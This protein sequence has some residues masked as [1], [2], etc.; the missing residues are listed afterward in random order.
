MAT[1]EETDSGIDRFDP[2]VPDPGEEWNQWKQRWEFYVDSLPEMTDKRKRAKLLHT[3]GSKVQEIYQTLNDETKSYETA[4]TVLDGYFAP[5]KNK[6]YQRYLFRQITPKPGQKVDA[7]VTEL[8]VALK[9]CS[10]STEEQKEDV[11]LQQII[12]H[13][14]SKKLRRKILQEGEMTLAKALEWARLFEITESQANNIEE[15]AGTKLGGEESEQIQ[16]LRNDYMKGGNRNNVQKQPKVKYAIEDKEESSN[17]TH[18]YRCGLE[19]HFARACKIA[20][21]KTCNKCGKIGHFASVC[22]TRINNDREVKVITNESD[23][24]SNADSKESAWKIHGNSHTN[25]YVTVKIADQKL[26]MVM[27]TGASVNIV[28]EVEWNQL[29]SAGMKLQPAETKVYAYAS[30]EPLPILGQFI[31]KIETQQDS[32]QAKVLVIRGKAAPIMG[33]KT[34]EELNLVTIRKS[35]IRKI[36]TTMERII[37][38]YEQI[39][40]GRGK[41]TNYKGRIH[42]KQGAQPI[43]QKFRRVPYHLRKQVDQEIDRLLEEDVIEPV[44]GPTTWLSP[45]VYVP[46]KDGSI[47]ICVDM[48]QPNK[49]IQRQKYQ[50]RTVDEVLDEIEGATVIT[51]LDLKEGYHQIVLEDQSREVTTFATHRGNYRYKRLIYGVANAPEDFQ[52]VIQEM[53][54]DIN[55]AYNISDNTIIVGRNQQEHDAR[56]QAVLSRFTMRG[57]KLNKTKCKFGLSKIDFMGHTITG[58][59]MMPSA[60]KVKAIKEAR[61][62]HTVTELKSFLGLVNFCGRYIYDLASKTAQLREL[63]KSNV[64]W[65]WEK[66]HQ[67]EFEELKKSLTSDQVLA[68]FDKNAKTKIVTDASPVGIAAVLLQ[69]KEGHD[70]KPV[71]YVS[72]SLSDVEKRYSQTE[73]EALGV[74]W[75]IER[76]HLYLYGADFELET[77]HK[78][79]EVIYG[80]RSKPSARIE[81]WMLRLMPYSFSIVYRPGKSNIADPLSRLIREDKVQDSEANR[82]EEYVHFIQQYAKP[83]AITCE[84]IQQATQ[85]DEQLTRVLESLKTGRWEDKEYQKIQGELA[86]YNGILLRNTRI[87][88]PKQLRKQILQIMHEFHQGIVRSKQLLRQKVWWPNIDSEVENVI[89]NCLACQVIG[90]K[91]KQIPI[92]PTKLP[93]KPWDKI[94]IDICGPLPSGES[95][96]AIVDYYSRWPEAKVMRTTSTRSI[97]NWLNEVFATWGYPRKLKTDNGPQFTSTEFKEQMDEWGIKH[98]K[99]IPY[100]PQANGLVERMNRVIMKAVK[101]AK[102]ENKNWQDAHPFSTRIQE[103]ASHHDRRN[104]SRINDWKKNSHEITTYRIY[105]Q[106]TKQR[107]DSTRPRKKRENE[108][109]CRQNQKGRNEDL[110]TRR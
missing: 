81:R 88:I 75:G 52:R 22:R 50:M 61:I 40:H 69:S 73:K 28:S 77:D 98:V 107:L 91:Q 33:K 36:T 84:E 29:K 109:R 49:E 108:E 65:K 72:R 82:A 59:G 2:D 38:N 74:V 90:D 106:A 8:K 87:V 43:A 18:C 31:S 94:A 35:E 14:T 12:D 80:P 86:E 102:V 95:I 99:T 44:E 93:D 51:E 56:L 3:A 5:K 92:Q 1:N 34:L 58:K 13:C 9:W 105:Q 100:W 104:S 25:E 53:I 110:Q 60:E 47:R 66:K 62:P 103:Y 37:Q 24:E 78:P 10:Y 54:A 27:D 30:Q 41:I 39:F 7:W 32:T 96:I 67:K 26:K 15:N 6:L 23:S 16:S 11:I 19:G 85:S 42:V 71:I 45:A 76:C 64:K 83:Q 57:V 20:V 21:G 101:V 4:I 46:K 97:L 48:R 17:K 68:Y 63:T 89:N 79:L 70:Y 55:G